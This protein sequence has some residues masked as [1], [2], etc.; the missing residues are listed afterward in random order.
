[1]GHRAATTG[2]GVR[3][4][5]QSVAGPLIQPA[6]G[7]VV[8][9]VRLLERLRAAARVT[10]I[11]G[12]A[13]SGKTIL[14]RSWIAEVGQAHSA[15][16][17]AERG[18]RD[19]QRFWL[20]VLGALRGT[21]PGSAL[22][23]ELTPAPDLDGW[24]IVELLLKDLSSLRDRIWLVIDDLHELGS[25]DALRQLELLLLRAPRELR[26]VLTARQDVRLGLHR[27]RL[28]GDLTEIRPDDL[29]FSLAEARHL[30]QTAGVRLSDA[31]LALLYERTEGWAAGLRLAALSLAGHR[32]PERF[33]AEFSGTERTVA[34]YLLAE[35]LDR[36]P[37][38]VR[39]LLLRTSVLERVSGPLADA[40][41][42]SPGGERIL[43]QL[44]E[45]N[46]FVVSLD[47]ARSWFRFHHLFADLLQQELRRTAPGEV[48]ALHQTAA[49][50]FAEHGFPVEAIGHAQ[51]A[52]DWGMAIR[53]LADH[54][55]GLQL[56]GQAT[57]VHTMLAA[58]PAGASAADAE[59]A[60]LAAADEL[61]HGS[62]EAAGRSLES[63]ARAAESV[64]A[65]R[66]GQL[67]LLLGVVRLLLARQRADLPAVVKE[68]GRLRAAAEDPDVAQPGLGEE[69]RALAL[70]SLGT[71][72]YWAARFEEASRHLEQGVTLAR[73]IERPYLEFTGR[74]YQAPAGL[75]RSF[76][77]SAE[78][79]RQAIELARRHGWLDEPTVGVAYATLAYVLAWQGRLEEAET[80]I[81]RAEATIRPEAE[82]KTAVI[83]YYVRGI[84][85]LALGHGADAL[86]A[87]RA[88]ERLS[89]SLGDTHLV[90]PRTREK[91]L[92]ALVRMGEIEAAGRVL[93]SLSDQDR[94][95]GETHIARAELS[96]AQGD[97]RAASVALAPVL[98]GAAPLVRRAWLVS[99]RHLE[100]VVRDALGDPDAADRALESALEAAEPDH[101]RL[102]FLIY[103]AP[104]LLERHALGC[105]KHAALAAEILGLL[106]I[107]RG[108]PIAEGFEGMASRRL[109]VPDG[110]PARLIDPLSESEI[111][112]LR[113]LPTHLSR[114]EIA[115]EL[116]VSPNTVKTHMRHLYDK[117]GTHRRAEA[118]RRARALGLLAPSPRTSR[119]SQR[120]AQPPP[121]R[122]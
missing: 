12:S 79:C 38:D 33:A 36:Q 20:S 22:V 15:A 93:A 58:F 6:T 54:W 4:E 2:F 95:R 18:E 97:P 55:A 90:V 48:T 106:P 50:W 113:Y 57:T 74:A 85:E 104:G 42:G 102:P 108:W 9:R 114:R 49:N 64:P 117:L 71:T 67:R 83:A 103:P 28:E 24:A 111:R 31:A 81:E 62:L 69:L 101:I 14:I 19:P 46:A 82:P 80:W 109:T 27:L 59:L 118:I 37:A 32:D 39:L 94:D 60:V 89:G 41:T 21:A 11:S 26:F 91:R 72:E 8:A 120:D 40:I 100:A 78:Y 52:Q 75:E 86:V 44:E 17:S 112:V 16:V 110:S 25:A 121:V 51:A 3:G 45:A 61:A 96:L 13:G 29:R 7:G 30:F 70:I 43:Q 47:A 1:M 23:R 53:L 92:L 115:N 5:P 68:A 35:V 34:E 87:L 10:V 107:G 116:H 66:R 84:I 65:S 122:Q 119:E 88:A 73:Q 105:A 98:N 99:A 76:A 77:R 63:A 56:T